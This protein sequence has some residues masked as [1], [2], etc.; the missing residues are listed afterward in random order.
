MFAVD[1]MFTDVN[2]YYVDCGEHEPGISAVE[3][4]REASDAATREFPFP[5]SAGSL[6]SG[7]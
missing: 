5:S 6:G 2:T 4:G 1:I 7:G 3:R